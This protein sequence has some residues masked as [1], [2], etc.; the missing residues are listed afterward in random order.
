[1]LTTIGKQ[2]EDL[3]TEVEGAL[4]RDLA[5]LEARES[6]FVGQCTQQAAATELTC[7]LPDFP[8]LRENEHRQMEGECRLLEKALAAWLRKAE[9]L[10]ATLSAHR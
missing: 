4:Q 7:T 1:M 10:L 5:A 8:D 9:E 2:V 6:A 3:V